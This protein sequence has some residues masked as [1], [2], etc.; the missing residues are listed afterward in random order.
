MRIQ[1][2]D[3]GHGGCAVVTA[4]NGARIMLDC[5]F[6]SIREWFPS[7]AYAGETIDLL[8]AT[9]LDE[10][11]LDD[12][13][14][15]WD[16]VRIGALFTNPSVTASALRLMKP[17]GMR[18][19]VE[20][21]HEL[22]PY[23]VNGRLGT[24]P[25]DLGG[26]TAWCYY[27]QYPFFSE[28]NDL[29]L[30][31]FIR[32]SGFTI[33]FAGDLERPGWRNLLKLADFAA[34]L[35]SVNVLFAS[36]HGRESGCCEEAFQFLRPHIVIFSDAGKQY[37]T[38]E[39]TRWYGRRVKGIPDYTAPTFGGLPRIRKV[40]TTRSDG[41]IG[42]NVSPTGFFSVQTERSLGHWPFPELTPP[43][44]PLNQS[45]LLAAL[46]GNRAA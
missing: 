31:V 29:S 7:V 30:A 16:Q 23:L 28:T 26:A 45:D 32:F 33:L 21:M 42:I 12:L 14:F 27:N 9:N 43:G 20:K 5:G 6:N 22:L 19:G 4:P 41:S 34:D 3:V 24:L 46:L 11:H 25:I 37:E 17:D 36:H 44:Q 13:P 40:L 35:Q 8:V 18:Q 38:Q 15:V 10:D 39:T 1:V 2:F